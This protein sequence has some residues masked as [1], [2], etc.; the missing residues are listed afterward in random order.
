[1]TES[2]GQIVRHRLERAREALGEARLLAEGGRWNACVNRLYYACFY[3]VSALLL[4]RKLSSSKHT[5][6]RSLFNLHFVKPAE[7][8]RELGALYNDLFENRQ[9]GDYMDFVRFE[10]EQV[11][12]WMGQVEVFVQEI[13]ALAAAGSSSAED[14][15]VDTA[16]DD[17]TG[18]EA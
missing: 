5:G 11:R 3:A 12:P 13:A 15:E 18:G 16:L 6:V 8:S 7:V 14:G 2:Q 9:K 4:S 17:G 1:M 10:A